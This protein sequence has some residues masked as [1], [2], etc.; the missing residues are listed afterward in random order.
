MTLDLKIS[1]MPNGMVWIG[2]SR[3]GYTEGINLV[4]GALTDVEV[5]EF[6]TEYYERYESDYFA[7][8]EAKHTNLRKP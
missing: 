4:Q 8:F 2:Y 3:G 6:A 1:T 5:L 7:W